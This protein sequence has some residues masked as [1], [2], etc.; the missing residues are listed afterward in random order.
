MAD[1]HGGSQFF[2]Q[3]N[4]RERGVYAA[5]VEGRKGALYVRIGGSDQEWTPAHSNYRDYR[6]YARGIGWKVWVGLPGNPEVQQ[7][8]LNDG[9]PIPQY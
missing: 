5:Y 2:H 8:P 6:E 3:Q 4:A 9:L 7:A 1:V